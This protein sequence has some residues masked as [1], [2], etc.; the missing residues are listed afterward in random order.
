MVTKLP[1][2]SDE[3]ARQVDALS[4][5]VTFFSGANKE[6]RERWVCEALLKSLEI[7]FA[8]ADVKSS[9][10]DPPDVI[11]DSALFEV[12][13]IMD[14]DR[15]RHAEYKLA[16]A[17]ALAPKTA[18]T[19]NNENKEYTPK[20]ITP[21]GVSELVRAKL[22]ELERHYPPAVRAELDALFYVNLTEHW[23]EG[24]TMP[25]PSSFTTCGWRSVSAVF[26][27]RDSFVF[28]AGA[29]A[30]NFLRHRA[31]QAFAGPSADA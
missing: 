24:G 14:A 29:Q 25:D 23:L 27:G 28:Y 20:D 11:F 16:L 19:S 8:A 3:Q 12:K 17:K 2:D 18:G 7:P 22:A 5:A 6:T 10:T 30:P 9:A 26:G 31:G 13:E 1:F 4:A 21:D 15:R